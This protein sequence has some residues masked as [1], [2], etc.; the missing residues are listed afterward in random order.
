MQHAVNVAHC[1][2]RETFAFAAPFAL[3]ARIQFG[4][5]S[6]AK[7]L[8]ADSTDVRTDVLAEK[9]AIPLECFWA[10]V[11]GRPVRFPMSDELSYRHS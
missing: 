7:L 4:Q 6:R 5:R 8:Q 3:E 9:L 2:R 10:N 11:G 1:P